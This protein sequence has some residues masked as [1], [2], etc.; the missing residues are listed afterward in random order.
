[1]LLTGLLVLALQCPLFKAENSQA[2]SCDVEHC[3]DAYA[4]CF[5][6]TKYACCV[7]PPGFYGGG[8]ERCVDKHDTDRFIRLKGMISIKLADGIYENIFPIFHETITIRGPPM[9]Q[10]AIN[11]VP[12]MGAVHNTFRLLTPLFH[13]IN[14]INSLPKENSRIYNIFSLSGGFSNLVHIRFNLTYDNIGI[15]V[16]DVRIHREVSDSDYYEG[17]LQVDVTSE[18]V[19]KVPKEIY[20]E[21]VFGDRMVNY[22]KIARGVLRIE[23]Q[24]FHFVSKDYPP[25][26]LRGSIVGTIYVSVDES[27]CLLENGSLVEEGKDAFRVLLGPKGSCGAAC[28]HS[29]TLCTIYCLDYPVLESRRQLDVEPEGIR[30]PRLIEPEE[31]DE[32]GGDEITSESSQRER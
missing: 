11:D 3:R 29:S 28:P 17:K 15:L 22:S 8:G 21:K 1:M 18:G 12:S 10:M 2:P 9:G 32:D 23:R 14:S 26:T 24:Q 7:C 5:N 25:R 16:A 13:F 19:F 27:S 6:F 20:T 30:K 4:E 31:E